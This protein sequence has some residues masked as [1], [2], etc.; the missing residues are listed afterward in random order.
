MSASLLIEDN[1]LSLFLPITGCN[2]KMFLNPLEKKISA[3]P[4]VETAIPSEVPP[5]S[6]CFLAI[7]GVRCAST[8]GLN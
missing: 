6:I 7:A 1:L 4:I 8:F 5:A 2:T 3:C